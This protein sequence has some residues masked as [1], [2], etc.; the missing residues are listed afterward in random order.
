MEFTFK[1][2]KLKTELNESIGG[3]GEEVEDSFTQCQK[4]ILNASNDF[5]QLNGNHL[6][7][8]RFYGVREFLVLIPS[9]RTPI[10]D[11]T[12]IK[13]LV[14]SLAIAASNSNW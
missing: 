1:H 10:L 8:A 3:C 7:I 5:A 6:E 13:I 9:K 12:R 2:Y 14:S 11:E 4:D